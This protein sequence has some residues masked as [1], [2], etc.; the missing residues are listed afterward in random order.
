MSSMYDIFAIVTLCA[1]F[2]YV[3]LCY[4][5]APLNIKICFPVHFVM[6][7]LIV[8]TARSVALHIEAYGVKRKIICPNVKAKHRSQVFI[9]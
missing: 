5:R 2:C 7:M 6:A 9:R 8:K 4:H 1:K 3:E